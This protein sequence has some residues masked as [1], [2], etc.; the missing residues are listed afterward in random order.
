MAPALRPAGIHSLPDLLARHVM[1]RASLQQ[2]ARDVSPET[3][4]WPSLVDDGA[5]D[6]RTGGWS[7]LIPEPAL[8]AVELDDL[9]PHLA[10]D[11]RQALHD[12][13]ERSRMATEWWLEMLVLAESDLAAALSSGQ[14]ALALRPDNDGLKRDVAR[15]AFRAGEQALQAGL[16]PDARVLAELAA[17]LDPARILHH[18]L[19]YDVT[20]RTRPAAAAQRRLQNMGRRF[21]EAYPLLLVMARYRLDQGEVN[22]AEAFLRR[23]TDTGFDSAAL[24]LGW[25]RVEFARGQ[26]A[27]GRRQVQRALDMAPDA[28]LVLA[29]IGGSLTAT[30]GDLAAGFLRQAL[31]MGLHSAAVT[32]PLGRLALQAGDYPGAI[33]L[34]SA[35]VEEVPERAR[36]RLDLGSALLG[37]G[38]TTEAVTHLMKAR[39]LEPANAMV[40]L[41]L[42]AALVREGRIQ[43]ARVE[44]EQ[45]GD[46]LAGNPVYERLRQ[47]LLPQESGSL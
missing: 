24:H 28:S 7:D 36:F 35:A 21:P 22:A 42:A 32:G 40:R 3:R 16:M 46:G 19:L 41:N 43:E 31:Q 47:E 2:L 37:S 8:L 18:L 26:T 1:P 17:E 44:L 45:T 10:A 25:A 38:R 9:L 5:G 29:D 14:A 15:I 4:Y 23:A 12:D 34:L 6:P 11:E 13:L 30:D 20:L 39:D 27:A 33:E